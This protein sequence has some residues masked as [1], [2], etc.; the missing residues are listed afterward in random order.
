MTASDLLSAHFASRAVR[1]D[2]DAFYQA[3]SQ[4]SGLATP[5]NHG[6]LSWAASFAVRRVSVLF[7]T[8]VRTR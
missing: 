6:I 5:M 8:V 2:E 3:Y 4:R 7:A 1:L